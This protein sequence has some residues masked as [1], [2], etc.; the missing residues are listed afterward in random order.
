MPKVMRLR[1]QTQDLNPGILEPCL[2]PNHAFGGSHLATVTLEPVLRGGSSQDGPLC[3]PRS[4]DFPREGRQPASWAG[5]DVAQA[6]PVGPKC[7][8]EEAQR[9]RKFTHIS[10]NCRVDTYLY[11]FLP[12]TL[13]HA[14][15][16]EPAGGAGPHLGPSPCSA[17]QTLRGGSTSLERRAWLKFFPLWP[18]RVQQG[19]RHAGSLGVSRC[20]PGFQMLA[21]VPEGQAWLCGVGSNAGMLSD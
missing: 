16:Q 18:H 3:C 20:P 5:S 11:F 17:S 2:C 6:S 12:V 8:E 14:A 21:G 15:A 19:V 13:A 10:E 7:R 9:C 1:Q 4:S